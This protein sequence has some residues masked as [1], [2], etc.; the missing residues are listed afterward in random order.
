[1][2]PLMA[3]IAMAESGGNSD[4]RNTDS[5]A[6]GLWQIHPCEPGSNNP[7]TNAQIAVR[8]YNS[9]GL[10]AWEAYT[11]GSYKRFMGGATGTATSASLFSSDQSSCYTT[12]VMGN[13]ADGFMGLGAMIL[14]AGVIVAMLLIMVLNTNEA[15]TVAKE[16]AKVAMVVPK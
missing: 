7:M 1:V 14:G 9:Q 8:K 5:G 13:C 2:A 10:G 4:A 11:N 16:A 3:A 12:Q 15:K 6:C